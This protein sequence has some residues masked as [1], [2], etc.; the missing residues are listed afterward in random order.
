MTDR[1]RQVVLPDC[2]V[3]PSFKLAPVCEAVCPSGIDS[4]YTT[5]DGLASQRRDSNRKT[6][7]AIEYSD[8][9]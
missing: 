5:E 6:Q 9:R 2:V 7:R 1:Q 3:V 8:D 4:K